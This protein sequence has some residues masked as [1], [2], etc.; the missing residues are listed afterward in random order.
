[1]HK[2]HTSSPRSPLPGNG[3]PTA[4]QQCF[5]LLETAA[6]HVHTTVYAAMQSK[7]PQAAWQVTVAAVP[8]VSN[9][10]T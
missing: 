8:A 1:M 5:K 4:L 3:L 9:S 6:Q 10:R 7:Q 2:V